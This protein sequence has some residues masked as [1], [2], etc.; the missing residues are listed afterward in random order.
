M[1]KHSFSPWVWT[2]YNKAKG[3]ITMSLDDSEGGGILF[4]NAMWDITKANR[5]LIAAAP[6]LLDALKYMVAT[7]PCTNGCA[8]NDMSCAARKAEEA[9]RK[10]EKGVKERD[11]YL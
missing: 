3:W 9:I 5:N 6:D 8:K 1:S 11:A 4:H 10:A 2:I 7:F